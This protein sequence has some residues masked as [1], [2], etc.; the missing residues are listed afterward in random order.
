MVASDNI[1]EGKQYAL[2]KKILT[3]SEKPIYASVHS[4]FEISSDENSSE[5]F[6][7]NSLKPN[8]K[9]GY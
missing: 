1:F 5:Q 7:A 4:L 3:P 9:E 8:C 6:I 2:F